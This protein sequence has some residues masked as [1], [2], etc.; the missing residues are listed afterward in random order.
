MKA[1]YPLRYSE[2][3]NV[4]SNEYNLDKYLVMALIKTESNYIYDA[5]SGVASGLMQITSETATWIAEKTDIVLD[6]IFN[7]KTNINMGC[8]YLSYLLD[9]YDYDEKLALCAYN[10]GM[11]N[12]NKWLGNEEYSKDGKTLDQIPFAETKQY[13]EKIEKCKKIY[14]NLYQN[15]EE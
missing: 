7:P 10:A 14:I 2:Y 3:I 5:H 1:L 6:D 15:K 4:Y 13:I 9:Y 8:Y 11:G 12:V